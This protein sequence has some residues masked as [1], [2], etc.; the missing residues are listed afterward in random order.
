MEYIAHRTVVEDHDSAE[1][2]LDLA[3]IFDICAVPKCAVLTIVPTTEIGS[4]S[5]E[6]VN[7]RI[8][9]LLDRRGEHNEVVP[10]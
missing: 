7:Y 6:P 2:W 1:I 3:Q 5:L 4:L 10:F 9:V 8:G